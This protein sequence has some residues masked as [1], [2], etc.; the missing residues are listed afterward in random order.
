MPYFGLKFSLPR[1]IS[2]QIE[3]LQLKKSDL[4]VKNNLCG[5]VL[6]RLKVQF[7][8]N[9]ERGLYHN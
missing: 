1:C 8:Q 2:N 7:D 6:M 4:F 9:V 3:Y 5:N